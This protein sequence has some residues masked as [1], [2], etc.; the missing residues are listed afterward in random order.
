[1]I[2]EG[3]GAILM[4]QSTLLAEVACMQRDDSS[5]WKIAAVLVGATYLV[6]GLVSAVLAG[7]ADSIEMRNFWRRAAWVVSGVVFAGHIAFELFAR[8]SS[9]RM[10]AL[11]VA[12]AAALGSFGL[13]VAANLHSQPSARQRV[14]LAISLVAWPA[15][16]A[17]P[18]FLVALVA[19][20]GMAR[21]EPHFKRSR[22]P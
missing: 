22:E 13:A 10:S 14:L 17:I 1:L 18:A 21:L 12:I 11:H 20:T 3:D 6:L 5:R 15:I 19:A 4:A 9:T 7:G 2:A 8:R 16:T